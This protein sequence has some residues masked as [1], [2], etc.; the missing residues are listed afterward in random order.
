MIAHVVCLTKGGG[1]KCGL[2]GKAFEAVTV[3][4]AVVACTVCA[5]VGLGWCDGLSGV[6]GGADVLGE[7]GGRRFWW[8]FAVVVAIS[9]VRDLG[10]SVFY[11]LG[12]GFELGGRAA[13]FTWCAVALPGV[14]I[15]VAG[16]ADG[17]VRHDGVYVHA[18]FGPRL[19]RM[20][21]LSISLGEVG[22]R[23][24][25]GGFPMRARLSL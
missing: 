8:T 4:R 19:V 10:G 5:R 18:E 12:G 20:V 22:I 14:D 23:C 21:V 2:A 6:C 17:L 24:E 15:R 1:W 16:C 3:S 11:W 7:A 13:P 9:V 25:D